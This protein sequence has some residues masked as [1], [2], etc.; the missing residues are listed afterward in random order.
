M[1]LNLSNLE[2]PDDMRD[3]RANEKITIT[4][5]SAAMRDF[6]GFKVSWIFVYQRLNSLRGLGAYT[7]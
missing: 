3:L 2:F 1:R 6:A 4:K 7:L 5:R